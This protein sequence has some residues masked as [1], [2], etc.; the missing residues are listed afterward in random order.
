VFKPPEVS[1]GISTVTPLDMDRGTKPVA[2]I[3]GS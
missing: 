1:T 3:P 2:S